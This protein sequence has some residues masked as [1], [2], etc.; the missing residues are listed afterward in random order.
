MDG[1][2]LRYFVEVVR[3]G[4]FTRAS[5]VLN[6]TQPAISKMIRQL[7]DQLGVPLLIRGSKGI[8]L[9]DAGHIA[10]QHGLAILEQVEAD[11]VEAVTA[12]GGD[13]DDRGNNDEHQP[14]T[15]L[16]ASERHWCLSLLIPDGAGVSVPASP[17]RKITT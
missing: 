3:Q 6:V 8:R 16:Q 17:S 11:F 1:R 10:Y 12:D 5:E 14:I 4:G 7:E 15:D 13:A 9:T 2:G